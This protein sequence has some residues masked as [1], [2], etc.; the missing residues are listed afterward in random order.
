[1]LPCSRRVE[2]II[3]LSGK[4]VSLVILNLHFYALR[5]FIHVHAVGHCT[6][7]CACSIHGLPLKGAMQR[8]EQR[9]FLRIL[10]N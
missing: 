4:K 1:M 8:R 5:V 3:N 2:K 6:V 10:E 7:I 9:R